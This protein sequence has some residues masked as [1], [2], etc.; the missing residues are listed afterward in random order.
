VAVYV[1]TGKLGGGKT[2]ACVDRIHEA[3]AQGRRVATNLD[4]ELHRFPYV[5][6]YAKNVRVLRC[7]DKPSA[8]DIEALG[9]GTPGVESDADARRLYDEKRFGC[10]VLDECGTWFNA[11]EWSEEGRRELINTL[12][13]I[14][15]KLWHVYL[16]VQDISMLD[17]QARKALAEHVVY[18]RRLDRLTVP[19]IGFWYQRFT[20]N[21]MPLPQVHVAFVKYGD[22][23]DSL[24]VERWFY[25]GGALWS[26]YDT[27]QVFRDDY[28]HGL[29]S[30]LPP[31][32]RFGHAKLKWSM[33][34]IMRLTKIVFRKY[35]MALLLAAGVALGAGFASWQAARASDARDLE[36]EA[37][38]EAAAATSSSAPAER[39]AAADKPAGPWVV[40]AEWSHDPGKWE[41]V[42]ER[43]GAE[44]YLEDLGRYG[45]TASRVGPCVYRL[46]SL[47][48]GA[49]MARCRRRL[50]LPQAAAPPTE[51]APVYSSGDS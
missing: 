44:T 22:R 5:G 38:L 18:C 49:E 4:L 11:R 37:R 34:A 31:F 50:R 45:W 39:S 47:A 32:Y 16:I 3:L 8:A 25:R 46:I 26:C 29:F 40:V 14:R 35:S 24:T 17:K 21:K 28:P 42:L 36:L 20:G 27:T 15:K 19:F 7:P 48:G 51:R 41:A 6:R 43:D 1:V 2:L 13:H 12:L 33:G 23:P 10:L 9:F 30:V